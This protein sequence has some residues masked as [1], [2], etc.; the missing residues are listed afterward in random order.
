M[1]RVAKHLVVAQ[2]RLV[3]LGALLLRAHRAADG[4]HDLGGVHRV[5]A[6]QPVEDDHVRAGQ[7]QAGH[8]GAARAGVDD[9]HAVGVVLGLVLL[10]HR[11]GAPADGADARE[12]RQRLPEERARPGGVLLLVQRRVVR[13][14]R[15]AD[16]AAEQHAQALGLELQGELDGKL[17][18]WT[19]LQDKLSLQDMLRELQLPVAV[20]QKPQERIDHDVTTAAFGLWPEVQHNA[21]GTVRVDGL[22]VHLSETDWQ[23]DKA[24][25]CL[26]EHNE[27][28]LTEILGMTSVE[29]AQLVEEGII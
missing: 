13:L 23:F 22:P 6:P 12:L 29:V 28:V 4:L 20:V 3:R 8:G 26:G 17:G 15:A 1:A 24:G 25:P 19:R 18:E 9:A 11:L 7:V 16:V 10:E 21:I 27:K 5:P 2:V 14:R